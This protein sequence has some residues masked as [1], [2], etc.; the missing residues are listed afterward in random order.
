LQTDMQM[1]PMVYT[2]ISMKTGGA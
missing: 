1:L 2:Y